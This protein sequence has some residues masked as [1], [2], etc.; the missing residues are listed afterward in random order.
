MSKIS[1]LKLAMHRYQHPLP[2]QI[3][4]TMANLFLECSL[5]LEKTSFRSKNVGR[6]RYFYLVFVKN[7]KTESISTAKDIAIGTDTKLSG[8]L[9][10]KIAKSCVYI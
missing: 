4:K 6:H 2:V 8:S 7:K 9:V 3:A 5:V 10:L 1:W